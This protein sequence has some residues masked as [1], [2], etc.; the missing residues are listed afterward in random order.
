MQY[1]I[2]S[3]DTVKNYYNNGESARSALKRLINRKH[4][5]KI[6]N[7]MYTCIS[8]E[9]A[10]PIANRF[11]IASAITKTSCI[12]HHTAFEYYGVMDQ[13]YYDVYVS[14]ETKFNPFSF[15]G[16]TY[17]YIPNKISDGIEQVKLSGGVKIT[18]K[19]RTLVDS[20]KDMDKISGIEEVYS[21][22]SLITGIDENK[23]L[24]YL[25]AYNNKSLYQRVGFMLYQY[26]EVLRLSDSF[27]DACK[28]HIGKNKT[29]LSA[30]SYDNTYNREWK[31][32]I[33]KE[34]F[35]LKNGGDF[36]ND[37]I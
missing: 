26:K 12:S 30:E 5:K 4:V 25:K 16:Y 20:I 27:F 22:I 33:P 3:V 21:A 13:V 24:K 6:R 15:D 37:R 28:S 34:M 1:P 2:F 19:E 8:G 7:N 32:I 31:I 23:V 35:S 17:L 14:S 11:Q 36:V 9:S 18:D 10:A 29:Y